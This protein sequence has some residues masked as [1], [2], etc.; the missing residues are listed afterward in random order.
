[1]AAAR[2]RRLWAGGSLVAILALAGCGG[3][4]GRD[5]R[6]PPPRPRPRQ[7]TTTQSAEPPSEQHG[8]WAEA[9]EREPQLYFTAG[10]Q[11]RKVEPSSRRAARQLDAATEALVAGPPDGGEAET[12]I[13]GG[14]RGRGVD[15]AEDGTATVE[16]SA[17]FLDGIPA[18]AADRDD[19][20]RQELA[21]RLGQLTYTLTQFDE[22]EAVD[23]VAGGEPVE[24]DT[25]RADF[26]KPAKGP[27]R[28]QR[29]KGR[30]EL[31]HAPAAGAARRPPV[32]AA[33]RRRRGRGLSHPAGGD[34]VS[35]VGGPGARRG[36]RPGDDERRWRR[37]RHRSRQSGGPPRRIEVYRER[38]VALLIAGGRVKRAIHV[39]T[40]APG[41]L[42][43]RRHLRG[44]SQGAQ[45]LVGAVSGLA[46]LRLVLHRR[47]RLPRVPG[48]ARVPGLTRLRAGTRARGPGLYRFAKL[49]TTVVVI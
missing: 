12:Q 49:G 14:R 1:M 45:V 35:V 40:G 9:S 43:P 17:E 34:R 41:H 16:V 32:P 24:R 22:V 23:V 20:Q 33:Q 37:R 30:A 39:S 38:G 5:A 42:D 6:P 2:A 27:Q 7:S 44:L 18:A 26:A 19:L 21:A 4:D 10:E 36:R 13:P 3:G 25:D 15:V 31:E 8:R 28:K 46:A 11:F 47:D 48:R 29:P